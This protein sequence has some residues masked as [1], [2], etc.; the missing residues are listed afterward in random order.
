MIVTLDDELPSL[1]PA[2]HATLVPVVSLA[3]SVDGAQPETTRYPGG[4][5]LQLTIT[6]DTYQLLSP[7]WPVT[8]GVIT[9]GSA[10]ASGAETANPITASSSARLTAPPACARRER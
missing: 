9:G 2:T 3:I 8:V 5:M 6:L 10:E 1:L 7:V 4:L